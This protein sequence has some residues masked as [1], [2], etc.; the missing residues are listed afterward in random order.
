MTARRVFGLALLALLPA[1]SAF[2][3]GILTT[4]AGTDWLFPADG[5]PAINAPLDSGFS[6]GVITDQN[7]NFY[8]A[9]EG[10]E[11]VMRV[12]PDG[13][14][15]VIAGN[16]IILESG[17]GGL[18][19]NAGVLTPLSVAVDTAGNVYV[20]EYGGQIRKFMPGGNITTIAGTGL[21]GF[22]GDRGPATRAQLYS[23]YGIA[24]D[25]AGNVYIADTLN[26]RIREITTDGIIH[27]IAGG[28]N[29][30]SDGIA[31]TSAKLVEPQRIALD[32]AGNIYFADVFDGRV[33]KVDANG[34]ITTVAGGGTSSS[35]GVAATTEQLIP[36]GIGLDGLGNIYV[37]DLM[38][39][40]V[41]KVDAHGII[42]TVAGS[43]KQGFSGDGGPAL[44]ATF[45]FGPTSTVAV[46][47][48]GNLLVADDNNARIR[49]IT[50]DGKISTVAGNG[51]FRFSGNGGLA[52][53]ATLDLPTGVTGDQAGNIYFTEPFS[54][55]IR[56]LATDGTIGVFAG[57]GAQDYLGDGGP[58]TSA[59]LAYPEYLVFSPTGSL[60]FSDSLNCVIRAIDQNGIIS[61]IA[62]NGYCGFTGD[63]ETTAKTSFNA[64][65]GLD[66]DSAGDLLI[67]D[68]QNNRIRGILATGAD[69][70]QVITVAGNGTAGYSGDGKLAPNNSQINSPTGLR[71]H[72]NG[73]YFCD[74]GNNVVRY[75][76]FTTFF[77]T[78]VAGNGVAAY[79][80]DGGP[81][82]KASLNTPYGLVFDAQGNMYIADSG[83]SVIRKV[84]VSGTITTV[85]GG[86]VTG[87]GD[88]LAPLNAFIG[89]PHDLYIRPS[90][91]LV[92]T[93]TY[94]QRVREILKTLPSFQAN[95][96]NLAFTAA[97]G[98]A[99]LNQD[100]DVA[101]S[102]TG[103]PFTV[104][105]D[106][107]PW[108]SVSV[109][110]GRM[111]ADIGVTVNPASLAPGSYNGT[112]TIATPNAAPGAIGI[113]VA[114]TVTAAGQ[115]S[116]SVSPGSLTFPFVQQAPAVSRSI[117]VSNTGGGSLAFSAATSTTSG[118]SW[119]AAAPASATLSAFGSAVLNITANPA[120]LG[121][122]T[123]SGIVTVSSANPAQSIV[124][125]VTMT[126]TAVSQTIVIPETGLSFFAVQRGGSP[127]PQNIDI[128][129]GGAGQMPWSVTTSTLSGGQW[130][131]VFPA[132]GETDAASSVVPQVRVYANPLGLATGTY[133][134]MVQVSATGATNT[135]QYVSVVFTVLPAGSDL[136][137]IVQPSGIIFSAVAGA[138]PPGS[139]TVTV[140]S[141]SSA[142]VNFTSGVVIGTGNSLFQ[143]APQ[144]GTITQAQPVQIVVQ[145]V[146]T[147]LVPGIYRGAL[148][149]S[150][151]DGNTRTISLLLVVTA[152]S[153]STTGI[154]SVHAVQGSCTPTTLAPVFT[155]LTAGSNVPTGYP[156][157]IQVQ[158]VDDCA[159]P[160][161]TGS[162]TTTFSNGDP[163][164][165]LTS[166]KN[167][168]W[169]ATWTP[170]RA[171]SKIVVT[172]NAS[173]PAQNL[174]G[175][176]QITVGSQTAAALPVISPGGVVNAASFAALAP[177]APGSLVAVFGT[178]L[179][180]NQASAT[181][182]PLPVNLAGASILI[183]GKEAPLLFAS[184]GQ[185]NAVVP[186]GI[187]VNS[188]QQAIAT[189]ASALS[190]PQQL[191]I[192][193]AAPG[194]FTTDG[195]QGIV[196][197]VDAAGNQTL[198]DANHPAIIGHALVIYCTGLGEV[199]PP[200][201][202]GTAAPSNP[203][204]S[205]VNPVT[206]T[207]G[208][209]AANVLFAGL[210]P[211]LVGLYQVN[212]VIP[213]GVTPGPQVPLVLTSV[214][215][216]SAPV[217]IPVQ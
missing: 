148:T 7:G 120:G 66:Y 186:Y 121:P 43:G 146:T 63:L 122:G 21:T 167:G 99:A 12:G 59:A 78:T 187:P 72:G 216:V 107:S 131:S 39:E 208:G 96:G 119:L 101:G 56:R 68:T 217:T 179:A 98:S 115:P 112:V 118:G 129:N 80:G 76:D 162:V 138:Q 139:Q 214:G 113:P 16:G 69:A 9:D 143:S 144:T 91:E 207:I 210:T 184:N 192:A 70:G 116:L 127:P 150:F 27:T 25:A 44:N 111:P 10:N 29:S 123:Y 32:G 38:S 178:Q 42:T 160:I 194:V 93:D 133:Y 163:P 158:V 170:Q 199:S 71:V 185:V 213:A 189:V 215:Q 100:I 201:T 126:V 4:I 132:A 206:V 18:A 55:R 183:G 135:P 74:T 22:S 157:V 102:I 81:A 95:P 211:T 3:Q 195:K 173:I 209:V 109:T 34:I 97:A 154:G 145:P 153:G 176:A 200:V 177:L 110:A 103:I 140:Q 11:M 20:A 117:S 24:V 8:L 124:V 37:V 33:R 142:P 57:T 197:D 79:S 141:T 161:S 203:P 60:V 40:T 108:L 62:G 180:Q 47:S 212:V 171:S 193:A 14:I 128:L 149:L 52:T 1:G 105:T 182:I 30:S 31:A 134:G 168:S 19:V 166:L 205:T 17:D 36:S 147:G 13:I 48:S 104:A 46:D 28:G 174:A 26:H 67:A 54:N 191:T 50:T 75:V 6:L 152:G 85:A 90:G 155:A 41:K 77:I 88:G 159:N 125:P 130:L 35:D 94:Y 65:E 114:L 164:L 181:L 151:S 2:G 165:G 202:T 73:I 87:L 136:G 190:V 64:P 49:K 198:V 137:P 204:S 84:D 15:H 45:R 156:G 51:L 172:A 106:S 175:Q 61:T 89:G 86:G 23:P 196:V 53:S 82:T 169:V 5:L 92:F 58:A 83:N 188:A